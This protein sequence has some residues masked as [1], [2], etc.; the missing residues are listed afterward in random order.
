MFSGIEVEV[1]V[2]VFEVFL[3]LDKACG[4][5]FV[6]Q[7]G[8]IEVDLGDGVGGQEALVSFEIQGVGGLFSLGLG[9][10]GFELKDLGALFGGVAEGVVVVGSGVVDLRALEI[11]GDS[12]EELAFSDAVVFGDEGL[13]EIAVGI[14]GDFVLFL[15]LGAAAGEDG[16]DDVFILRVRGRGVLAGRLSSRITR[17]G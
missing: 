3:Q 8:V 9:D 7:A 2:E 13:L 1:G 14:G 10:L 6:G 4:G 12:E 15:C 16:V 17:R 5:C 11:V